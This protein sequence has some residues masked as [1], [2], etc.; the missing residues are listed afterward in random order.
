MW[1]FL[2][3]DPEGAANPAFLSCFPGVEEH[4]DEDGRKHDG[5][6]AEKKN[7]C[8]HDDLRGVSAVRPHS[9]H[10]QNTIFLH[11]LCL[12]IHEGNYIEAVSR[13]VAE[14]VSAAA[15]ASSCVCVR[16]ESSVSMPSFTPGMTTAA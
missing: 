7:E 15:S 3:R 1:A 16:A 2:L 10:R 9:H 4:V 5:E 13:T 11:C 14:R 6:D 12:G 8:V